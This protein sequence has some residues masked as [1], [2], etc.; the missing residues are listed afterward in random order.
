MKRYS[1]GMNIRRALLL[2]LCSTPIAIRAQST[3][4]RPAADARSVRLAIATDR[5]TYRTSDSVS[6]RLELF[7]TARAP[8]TFLRYPPWADV[9]LVV[10]DSAG[11]VVAPTKS[12]APIYIVSSRKVTIPGGGAQVPTWNNGEWFSLRNWGYALLG[13]GRYTIVGIPVL[14]VVGGAR[15]GSPQSNTVTITVAP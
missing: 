12:P 14:S 5:S 11:R 13:A 3:P 10:T 7:N 2:V 6:V 15:G 4:A 1:R 8:I 9:R